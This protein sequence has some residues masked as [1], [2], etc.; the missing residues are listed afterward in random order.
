[1]GATATALIG[2]AGWYILLSIAVAFY[3]VRLIFSGE[4]A[5]NAFATDGSDLAPLGR[6]LT[7]ARDNCFETLPLFVALALGASL[8]GRLDVT[9]GLAIWV[10]VLRIGQ[11]LS[12]IASTSILAVQVRATFFFAQILIYAYWTLRLL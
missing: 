9:D 7:R 11:S 1:M 2:F 12:H 8:A 3:R 10:L 6:R 4:K 5:A